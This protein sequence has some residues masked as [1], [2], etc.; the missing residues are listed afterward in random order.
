M[1]YGLYIRV[2]PFVELDFSNASQKYKPTI[3]GDAV[4]ITRKKNAG[5]FD[6]D[7]P[8]YTHISSNKNQ[9]ILIT[10]DVAKTISH[11]VI[12]ECFT[13]CQIHYQL[14]SKAQALVKLPIIIIAHANSHVE[15]FGTIR[16]EN[17]HAVISRT[18][19]VL[20]G[21]RVDWNELHIGGDFIR[22]PYLNLLEKPEATGNIRVYSVA[23]DEHKHDIYTESRHIANHTNSDIITRSVLLDKSQTLSRGLVRIEKDAFGSQGY[24]KQD[25]LLLGEH[26]QADAI[27]NLEIQNHDVSC[28]HGST[29]GRIDQDA[30]F[31]LRSR[32]ISLEQAQRLIIYSYFAPF[33]ENQESVAKILQEV[34]EL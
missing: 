27:P 20:E 25:A 34:L 23:R 4:E 21:A 19:R 18:A 12:V 3:Q 16:P 9:R 17:S 28:S 15:F 14:T 29:V 6:A 2:D 33:L 8:E 13:N 1:K 26:A 24:E 5:E 22:A 32:G 7:V 10:D 30:L 11:G 31:Y